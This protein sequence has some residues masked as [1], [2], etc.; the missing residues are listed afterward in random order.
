[1][2]RITKAMLIG[3]AA[4]LVALSLGFFLAG[5]INSDP[6][7][8]AAPDP[9]PTYSLLTNFNQGS[10]PAGAAW[11]GPPLA[12]EVVYWRPTTS[13][14]FQ[15]EYLTP[16]A[17]AGQRAGDQRYLPHFSVFT[18][19]GISSSPTPAG[20]P[21][22]TALGPGVLTSATTATIAVPDQDLTVELAVAIDDLPESRLSAILVETIRLLQI[23]D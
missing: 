12:G 18:S 1:M 13:E 3:I 11:L 19:P 16:L 17:A 5:L 20:Q 2:D 23:Q 15:V 10:P 14:G 21:I 9:K 6:E 22:K 8:P 4:G 7:Q